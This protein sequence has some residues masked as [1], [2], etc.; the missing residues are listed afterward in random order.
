[1][2]QQ[3]LPAQAVAESVVQERVHRDGVPLQRQPVSIVHVLLQPSP[4]V[5][6]PSSQAWPPVKAPSPHFGAQLTPLP[7]YPLL[8][9]QVK[10]PVVFVQAALALQLL[11]PLGPHSFTSA[12]LTPLPV[13]PLLHAQVKLPVVF[14]QAALALQLLPPLGPHSFTS[15]QRDGIPLHV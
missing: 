11:P 12:Q 1:V 4:A 7:V 15:L 9:A 10:L 13:Y 14:V 2:V 8:H 5:V 6:S 3:S